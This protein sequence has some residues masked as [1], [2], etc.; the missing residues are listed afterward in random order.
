MATISSLPTELLHQVCSYLAPFDQVAL[1]AT[2]KSFHAIIKPCIRLDQISQHIYLSLNL[3]TANLSA[4]NFLINHPGEVQTLLRNTYHGIL[5]NP[6]FSICG[7]YMPSLPAPSV[8][9]E[10]LQPYF[11]DKGF[12]EYTIAHHYFST[13]HKFAELVHESA[14]SSDLGEVL[15]WAH[16]KMSSRRFLQRLEKNLAKMMKATKGPAAQ[17]ET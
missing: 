6:K 14:L 15:G 2:S 7:K 17:Q 9:H 5:P 3:E 1:S 10:L 12:P 11:P 8:E 13:I 16:V 4:P